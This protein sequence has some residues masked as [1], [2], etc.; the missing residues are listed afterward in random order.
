MSSLPQ[1]EQT[2]GFLPIKRHCV[3]AYGALGTQRPKRW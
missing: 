3:V 2:A 1:P